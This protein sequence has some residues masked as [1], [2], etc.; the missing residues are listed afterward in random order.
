[1]PNTAQK[2]VPNNSQS[3]RTKFLIFQINW[4]DFLHT[5]WGGLNNRSIEAVKANLNGL[6]K[7]ALNGK[8]A[9]CRRPS[10]SEVLPD[11]VIASDAEI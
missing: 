1:M 8:C 2:V 3:D 7:R 9:P 4:R 10:H 5:I 6:K 11:W